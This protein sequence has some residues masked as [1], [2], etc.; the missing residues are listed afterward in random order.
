MVYGII[1]LVTP[2]T[3]PHPWTTYCISL[4]W[5]KLEARTLVSQAAHANRSDKVTIVDLPALIYLYVAVGNQAVVRHG[6]YT[7]AEFTG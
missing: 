1:T 7:Y 2:L 6:Y 4:E 3:R 5:P